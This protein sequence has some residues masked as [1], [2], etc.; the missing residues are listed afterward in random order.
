MTVTCVCLAYIYQPK[1]TAYNHAMYLVHPLVS[2]LV[3]SLAL[4]KHRSISRWLEMYHSLPSLVE[5]GHRNAW[6][7]D[8][9][10]GVQVN[11]LVHSKLSASLPGWVVNNPPLYFDSSRDGTFRVQ[12]LLQSFAWTESD[13][14]Q[15]LRSRN[16][17]AC[18]PELASA[19]MFCVETAV[20]L[21][22]FSALCY[23][24]QVGF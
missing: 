4:L 20:K 9:T 17:V 1:Q 21:S 12:A 8:S 22:Y 14:P 16:E 24:I 23:S 7:T 11:P 10:C 13:K 15:K 19:P 18:G 3:L 6:T 5:R 2:L